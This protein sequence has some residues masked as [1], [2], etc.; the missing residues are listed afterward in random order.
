[1]KHRGKEVKEFWAK[2]QDAVIKTGV[3][4]DKAVW[5]VHWAEKFAKAIKGKPLRQRSRQDIEDFLDNL[6]KTGKKWQV[7][8]A[9]EAIRVLYENFLQFEPLNGKEENFRDAGTKVRE[10]KKRYAKELAA[11]KSA[12]RIHHYSLRTEQAYE[13]WTARFM[14]FHDLKNPEQFADR[15]IK[16][17]LDYL[18]QVRQVAASTQNQALNAV[19]F[20][21]REVLGREAGDFDDFIRAKRPRRLPV[22]LTRDEVESLLA[23]MEGI[24][25][26]QA[27]LL[28]GSGLRL[29][30]CL[31]LR[32]KDIDFK[33]GQIM[34]RD[35]K[36]Q[37]DRITV[38]PQRFIPPLRQH[39]TMVRKLYREDR[40]KGTVGV[41]IWP[42]L[43]RKYPNAAKQWGWQY[44][45]PSARLSVDPRSGAVRR[46]HLHESGLQRA[47]KL[48]ANRAGLTKNVG[49]HT[50]RHCFATHLLEAGYDIRTVQELMGHK[51]VSTTMIY[52]HV[53]NR[54]GIAVRSPADG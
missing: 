46:H 54:P 36:G 25:R 15:E 37:Q 14:A 11:L 6:K 3:S 28:Y 48:A 22:V 38:L 49:C 33:Q 19:V 44:L 53:L 40:E 7:K 47:V 24:Y 39:L 50:L 27:G 18:A 1:M 17:Y 29:M 41:Y 12:L 10:A 26:L 20:F 30:E 13:Q 4:E 16:E 5:F 2:Y 32:I 23:E 35:G 9:G 52:T 42:A 8:Q 21:Y 51:D 31:R 43:A 34:V 45:F